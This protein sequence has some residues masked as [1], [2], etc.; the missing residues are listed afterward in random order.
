MNKKRSYLPSILLFVLVPSLITLCM[1]GIRNIFFWELSITGKQSSGNGHA[2]VPVLTV[3]LGWLMLFKVLVVCFWVFNFALSLCFRIKFNNTVYYLSNPSDSKIPPE[4]EHNMPKQ[5][6]GIIVM[7]RYAVLMI[8]P[9]IIW[10]Y[11]SAIL[12]VVYII[13]LLIYGIR[14]Y[15]NIGDIPDI[16]RI[17]KQGITVKEKL[18]EYRDIDNL[19][20]DIKKRFIDINLKSGDYERFY[21]GTADGSADSAAL[22]VLNTL[23]KTCKNHKKKFYFK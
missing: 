12:S 10:I 7:I 23:I 8:I 14:N 19:F 13:I 16:I 21:I 9:V 17:D 1:L 20:L 2:S 6:I 18:Y 11:V 22:Q 3:L 4:V 15:M 5:K